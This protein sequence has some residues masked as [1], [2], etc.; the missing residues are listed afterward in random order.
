MGVQLSFVKSCM[1]SKLFNYFKNT[2]KNFFGS[3]ATNKENET[4]TQT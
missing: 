4:N 2:I 1:T 3:N